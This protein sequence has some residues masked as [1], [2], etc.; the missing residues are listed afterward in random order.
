[1]DLSRSQGDSRSDGNEG[2]NG[3][4]DAADAAFGVND[5]DDDG[6][7][8]DG[9]A[10]R[11]GAESQNAETG[12]RATSAAGNE[13]DFITKVPPAAK[14]DEAA[15]IETTQLYLTR[16]KRM[17]RRRTEESL[18]MSEL[19]EAN[20]GRK[21]RAYDAIAND[22]AAAEAAAVAA[23]AE[24][25]EAV[26][27]ARRTTR[28]AAGKIKQVDYKV[29]AAIA[30][31]RGASLSGNEMD[32]S[33]DNDNTSG[34][35]GPSR[36]GKR[37]RSSQRSPRII[38]KDRPS[39]RRPAHVVRA[40]E[41]GSGIED[42][43]GDGEVGH[44]EVG[45]GEVGDGEVGDGEV[46]DGGNSP[47]SGSGASA[48][49][50]RNGSSR[51]ANRTET[52]G[53]RSASAAG[54]GAGDITRDSQDL[55]DVSYG[56]IAKKGRKKDDENVGGQDGVKA[57][58]NDPSDD[59]IGN[60]KESSMEKD[61]Q[62]FISNEDAVSDIAGETDRAG[63]D[64]I[65]LVKESI[66]K[67][68]DSREGCDD[69]SLSAELDEID[70]EDDDELRD[71]AGWGVVELSAV[72]QA[73]KNTGSLEAAVLFGGASK[74]D[75]MWASYRRTQ[76][77]VSQYIQNATRCIREFCPRM[78][79]ASSTDSGIRINDMLSYLAAEVWRLSSGVHRPAGAVSKL[80]RRKA[81]LRNAV[82]KTRKKLKRDLDEHRTKLECEM[83]V[84]RRASLET[85][86][87]QVCVGDCKRALE[88]EIRK[89][90]TTE[91]EIEIFKEREADAR[92]RTE[93]MKMLATQVHGDRFDEVTEEDSIAGLGAPAKLE[94]NRGPSKELNLGPKGPAADSG[95]L[96]KNVGA[97]VGK[98]GAIGKNGGSGESG[99][100]A[101]MEDIGDALG[102][103]QRASSSAPEI[104]ASATALEIRRLGSLIASYELEAETWQR[105]SE[106]ERVRV[107]SLAESK[108]RLE[109]ELYVQRHSWPSGS[110]SNGLPGPGTGGRSR[111]G[112]LGS[113]RV[114]GGGRISGAIPRGGSA[115]PGRNGKFS[116]QCS[117]SPAS[118]VGAAV[119]EDHGDREADSTGVGKGNADA[120]SARYASR[121]KGLPQRSPHA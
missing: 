17:V 15:G 91:A 42:P 19:I 53:R 78:Q 116:K 118:R 46:S 87:R 100:S 120:E 104:S 62:S 22:P 26:I 79:S 85:A 70:D 77:D 115:L 23:A 75:A 83:D 63:V 97:E 39:R 80:I 34:I 101:D 114:D 67:S 88:R 5:E 64:Q 58:G 59:D 51:G 33:E 102:E 45:N 108:N 111:D 44:G 74:A 31:A 109:Q 54:N 66:E 47:S 1:M 93:L 112:I 4:S 113:K 61:G 71:E 56:E 65:A 55:A 40:Q 117:S 16:S 9:E 94:T 37:Q 103:D 84:R 24:K 52:H 73:V 32:E 90:R 89:R 41:S 69:E 99:T 82:E 20:L 48:D 35:L 68:D 76:E 95:S 38:P 107:N 121:R 2:C 57:D 105:A 10:S 60:A 8:S 13:N 11:R 30:T 28:L 96:R 72:A 25:E 110:P 43:V 7:K 98:E 81:R 36:T 27:R 14:S 49:V 29:S 119:E 12:S 86:Y 106:S 50:K 21:G 18:S 3:A 6:V 92:E